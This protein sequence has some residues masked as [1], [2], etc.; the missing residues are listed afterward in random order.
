MTKG[1]FDFH[2][3]IFGGNALNYCYHLVKLLHPKSDWN[4]LSSAKLFVD[5]FPPIHVQATDMK[6]ISDISVM[7]VFSFCFL[8]M[9]FIILFCVTFINTYIE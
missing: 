5:S 9:S 2:I 8:S 4:L 6:N 3:N 7:K 1:K